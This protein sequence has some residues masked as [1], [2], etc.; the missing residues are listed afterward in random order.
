MVGGCEAGG[1]VDG[2]VAAVF[3]GEEVGCVFHPARPEA[4][5][6][7]GEVVFDF[8][9]LRFRRLGG[10]VGV[11]IFCGWEG[12]EAATVGGEFD[13]GFEV[14]EDVDCGVGGEGGRDGCCGGVGEGGF[15][16]RCCGINGVLRERSRAPGL[17]VR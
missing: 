14:V 1:G 5:G 13:D 9:V 15:E 4:F 3:H 8:V 11:A 17:R 16:H 6:D 2:D 10:A 7:E 12:F